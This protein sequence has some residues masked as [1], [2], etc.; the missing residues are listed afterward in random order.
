MLTH[1]VLFAFPAVLDLLLHRGNQLLL[2][3]QLQCFLLDV[4]FQLQ[5]PKQHKPVIPEPSFWKK[6]KRTQAEIW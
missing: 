4:V 2:V 3:C 1:R 5:G 6:L